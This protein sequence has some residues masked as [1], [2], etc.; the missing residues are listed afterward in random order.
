MMDSGANQVHTSMPSGTVTFLFTDIEG[1]TRLLERIREDFR[2]VIAEH[3]ALFRAAFAKWNG[4]EIQFLGDGFFAVFRRATDAVACVT[5]LQRALTEQTWPADATVR[6]RMGLHTGEAE[7]DEGHYV[8]IGVHRA[9]R[10]AAAGHGG[11]VLLSQTTRELVYMDLPKGVTL[12]SLGDHLLKDIRYPQPIYQ[13]DIEGLQTEFPALRSLGTEEPPAPGERPYKGLQCFGEADAEWFFGRDETTA[14]LA[15]DVRGQR[16]LAVV[17]ASGSG[18]SS[19]IRAGLL[20]ALRRATDARWE[21]VVIT[22]TVHPLEALAVGLTRGSESVI[23]AATLMDD[24]ARDTRSLHLYVGRHLTPNPSPTEYRGRGETLTPTLSPVGRGSAVSAHPSPASASRRGVGGEGTLSA[25]PGEAR[26]LLIVDQ[27]EELFTQCRNEAERRAFVDNLLYA[28]ES[29]GG[30]TT[31]VI[32]L[33]ADFYDHLAPYVALREAV[34]KHQEYIGPMSADE[35]RLAIEEPARRGGWEFVPGLVDLMLTDV[36]AGAGQQ[37]EPGALPLLSHALLETWRRRRGNTMTLRGYNEAGGVRGAIARTAENVFHNELTPQQQPIARNIFLRLTELGEGTQDTRRRATVSELIP[38]TSL[39]GAAQ[40]EEVLLK[41]ADARLITTG[42]GTVEV[43]HEALIREWPTLRQWLTADREGLRLHRHLTQAAQEWEAL[44]RDPGALYRGARLVQTAEWAEAH[45]A[46]LNT[47]E[48]AFVAA[49]QDLAQSEE[50]ER[51]AQR[52]RELVAAQQLAAA[53]RQRAEEQTRAA[54]RLRQ[55]AVYLAVALAAAAGLLVAALWL[56]RVANRN[57]RTAEEHTRLATSRELAAAAVNNLSVDAERSALLALEALAKAQ[58][59]EATNALHQALPELRLLRT[60]QLAADVEQVAFS[61]DGSLLVTA[62]SDQQAIVWDSST[63]KRLLGIG[64]SDPIRD[65]AFRPDGQVLA[66]GGLT[67]V[68]IFDLANRRNLFVLG[69]KWS[70]T[71]QSWESYPGVGRIAF[72]PDGTRL[73]VANLDGLPKVW[74]LATRSEAITLTGHAGK[75]TAIAYSPDGTRLATGSNDETV[76]I[77]DAATG[78]EL[79]KMDGSAAASGRVVFSPDGHRLASVGSDGTLTVWDVASGQ[80]VSSVAGQAIGFRDVAYTPDGK[81]LVT[82]GSDGT[83]RMWDAASGLQVRVSTGHKSAVRAVAV[84]P[85]GLILATCSDD[86]TAKVWDNGPGR[87]LLAWSGHVGWATDAAYSPDGTLLATSGVD[88]LIK[89][90]DPASGRLVMSLSPASSGGLYSLSWSPDG[91]RLAAGTGNGTAVAWDV[92]TGGQALTLTVGIDW[93]TDIAFSP[94]GT[95]LATS[96]REGTIAV[97][98]AVT[99][100]RLVFG[101]PGAG[102]EMWGIAFSPDG[103]RLAGGSTDGYVRIWEWAISAALHEGAEGIGVYSVAWSPDGQRLASG[104]QDGVITLWNAVEGK[105]L[106]TLPGHTGMVLRLAFSPNG[107]RL[108]SAALDGLAK[109][110][111]VATGS[112]AATL[113]GNTTSVF[114]VAFHPDGTHIATAALDGTV[115]TYTLATDELVAVAKSRLTRSLTADECRKFLHVD[116]C[117]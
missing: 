110:W 41:L 33:R 66:V 98:D 3:N 57:A 14:R 31:V 67:Q 101:R 21:I 111:D 52:Q 96:G 74:D 90:W 22:P 112:E 116:Q 37:P 58:T 85:E 4:R 93:I 105:R 117:P 47:L 84:S 88:N 75:A 17:G 61:P 48:Q 95:R 89:L 73:A 104:R 6:V 45:P 72:H 97:W 60:I 92:G 56:A 35:L 100:Q 82:A 62:H 18:K 54:S 83:V 13:L 42:E 46:E 44:A 86:G 69:T 80:R 65:V 99:G 109:V 19:I 114:G 9:A 76:R 12:R 32:A 108:A 63:G 8:G 106:L 29:E 15:E 68:T 53:E 36:G 71:Q 77:W 103:G 28:V 59:L 26:L 43:A 49:S 78:K 11:Q 51:E 20:P 1:S 64:S 81:Q 16:F 113:Y 115:R 2:A 107:T 7:V 40:V 87:E 79:R 55:R 91:K 5:E 25:Y 38:S 94:D 50:A 23:A 27:F 10:V 34:A 102:A 39:G 30:A 70:G 24:L